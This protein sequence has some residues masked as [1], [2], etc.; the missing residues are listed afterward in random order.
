MQE[1]T[2]PKTNM[3]PQNWWSIQGGPSTSYNLGYNSYN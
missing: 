2:P 3:E 1:Y